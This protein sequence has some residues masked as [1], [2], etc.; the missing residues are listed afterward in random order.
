MS[1]RKQGQRLLSGHQ[2][3]DKLIY[4]QKNATAIISVLVL[5]SVV[6]PTLLYI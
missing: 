2:R 1:L 4:S 3:A 5:P 6:R